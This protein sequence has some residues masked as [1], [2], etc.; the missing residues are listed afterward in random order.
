[1]PGSRTTPH[2]LFTTTV[3][4]AMLWLGIA[5]AGGHPRATEAGFLHVEDDVRLYYERYGTETPT[6]FIPNRLVLVYTFGEALERLNVVTWDPRGRGLSSYPDD[7]ARYG[8]D[9]EIADAEAI[10]RHFGADRITYLGISIW[11]NVALN[12]AAR[13]PDRVE[14]VIAL[15]PLPIA[16]RMM[17]PGDDPIVHELESERAE[18]QAMESDGRAERDPYGHCVVDSYLSFSGS[19]ASLDH[20]APLVAANVCQY[21]NERIVGGPAQRGMFASLGAWDWTDLA[22]GLQ[23]NVL[24]IY[25][26]RENW[27]IAGVRAYADALPN[28]GVAVFE[29]AGHHVWNE[30]QVAVTELV[31]TFALGAWPDGVVRS[32]ER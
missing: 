30:R 11:A 6:L 3:L 7:P 5:T 20:M 9:A 26:T 4:L 8:I 13:H 23:A 27:P 14:S 25:G 29:G 24:L 32:S 31:E 16:Q 21:P 17:G 1:M 2:P 15:G 18:L 10:R 28:V 19:Y 12:Y 22:A